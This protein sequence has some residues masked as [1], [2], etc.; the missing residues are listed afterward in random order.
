MTLRIRTMFLASSAGLALATPVQAAFGN[1]ISTPIP[2][3][4]VAVVVQ[5]VV[6][7]LAS[8]NSFIPAGDGTGRGFVVEQTGQI[9]IV[10]NSGALVATPFLDL[11]NPTGATRPCLR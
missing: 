9:R 4:P 7:A 5:P 10:N 8:P 11:S 3:G 6:T 2:L 1:P